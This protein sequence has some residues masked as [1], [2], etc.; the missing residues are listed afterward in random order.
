MEVQGILEKK[1]G[2]AM[3]LSPAA[4]RLVILLC[5]RH[6]PGILGMRLSGVLDMISGKL[7]ESLLKLTEYDGKLHR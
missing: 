6:L 5:L 7:R 3:E 2:T 1:E 4:R